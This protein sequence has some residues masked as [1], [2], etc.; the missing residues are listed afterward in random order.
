M[1]LD[2]PHF[3]NISNQNEFV[4]CTFEIEV[5]YGF[6]YVGTVSACRVPTVTLQRQ[7]IEVNSV[8]KKGRVDIRL[9]RTLNMNNKYKKFE[10]ASR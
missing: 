10:N 1:Y 2:F 8:I 4:K 9:N 7:G 6:P 5:F 3:H